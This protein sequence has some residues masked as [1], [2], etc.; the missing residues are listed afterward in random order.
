VYTTDPQPLPYPQLTRLQ[1][2]RSEIEVRDIMTMVSRLPQLEALDVLDHTKRTVELQQFDTG[3][4]SQLPKLREV[5]LSGSLPREL[6]HI[7]NIRTPLDAGVLPSHVTEQLT[8]LQKATPHIDWVLSRSEGLW[9][10]W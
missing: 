1:L 9:T 10:A 6:D 3:M 7:M 5:N 4:L 8:V 2:R